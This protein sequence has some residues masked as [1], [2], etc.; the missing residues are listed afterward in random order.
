MAALSRTR[1]R[2]C[3]SPAHNEQHRTTSAPR[4]TLDAA[5][6]RHARDSGLQLR[7]RLRI[8]AAGDVAAGIEHDVERADERAA[9]ER[10][11]RDGAALRRR[12]VRV[13]RLTRAVER[14][15]DER[16]RLRRLEPANP[17]AATHTSRWD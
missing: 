11:Q 2:E 6:W 5:V 9:G 14:P 3:G 7:A 16:R 13:V 12:G 15:D 8:E 17:R 4:C 1:S 10:R